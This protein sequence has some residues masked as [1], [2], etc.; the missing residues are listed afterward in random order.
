MVKKI[1]FCESPVSLPGGKKSPDEEGILYIAL[2]PTA[3]SY[4]A[5]KGMRVHTTD[6][7]F[8][9]ESHKKAL[10]RSKEISEWL[11]QHAPFADLGLGIRRGYKDP[12]IL[13]SRQAVH[14]FLWVTEI[15]FNAVS[16]HSPEVLS[17]PLA[18]RRRMMSL[19]AEPEEHYVG[20]IVRAVARQRNLSFEDVAGAPA[21]AQAFLLSRQKEYIR[22]FVRFAAKHLKFQIWKSV[23]FLQ[24][25]LSRKRPFFITTRHYQMDKIAEGLKQRLS[26]EKIRVFEGP[27]LSYVKIPSIVIMLFEPRLARLIINRR[28]ALN[29]FALALAAK[30]DAFSFN[31]ISFSG[32][33]AEKMAGSFVDHMTSL[34]L[35]SVKLDRCLDAIKPRAFL[36][37]GNR[38]DDI[39]LAELCSK[40]GIPTIM[41][42]HGSHVY[43]KNRLERIEWEE[44]GRYF[45][46]APFSFLALQS[47]MAEEY[48]KLLP[49][50]G[51]LLRTGPLSWGRIVDRTES[52]R[53]FKKMFGTRYD[54]NKVKIIVHAG[55]PKMGKSLR[56]YVYETHDEYL[57]AL[58][59]LSRAVTKMRDVIFI[60]RFRPSSGISIEDLNKRVDVSDNV[61]LSVDEPFTDVLG[62]SDLLV[63]FSSTA[64][65]EALQNRIPVL[66][67]GGNGRYQYIPAFSVGSDNALLPSAVYHVGERGI[68]ESAIER[69]FKLG[70]EGNGRDK[71]LFDPYIYRSNERVSLAD[72]IGGI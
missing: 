1:I 37:N 35:W 4:L 72:I 65:E 15:V 60:I 27:V 13:R 33:L 38:T 67:Y 42:S 59:D 11:R 43:P 28:K 69:I 70:I 57:Q 51:G 64:I 39:M 3:Y 25:A 63:S 46:G 44:H 41:I 47:P 55:T 34:Y 14:Y 31:G 56:L 22:H 5:G 48:L 26:G 19:T 10:E 45:L 20:C 21:V 17:A 30:E 40:K 18:G 58:S 6:I 2:T 32:E 9:N 66:L 24:T 23:L 7:Y 49:S 12:F 61:I 54:R 62:M 50:K 71:G 29:E 53:L 8:T 52:G 36:S 68:L 16:R